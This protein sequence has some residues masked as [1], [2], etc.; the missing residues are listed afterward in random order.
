MG[1]NSDTIAAIST[2]NG[3]GGISVIRMSGD[4]ALKIADRIFITVS[5]KK[6]SEMKGYTAAYGSVYD[7]DNNKLDDA[8]ATVFR[9]P[10]SYTGEDV[11]EISCHGGMYIT[12]Q[13]L[14]AVIESG[15]SPAK[16]G[17]FTQRAFLNGKMDLSEAEAVMDIISAK[18][19]TE[20]RAA[21]ACMDGQISREIF[22]IN[23]ALVS[24]AAHLSA[25]ADYPEEDIPEVNSDNLRSD[26]SGIKNMIE[27]LLKNYDAGMIIK[28]GID[29][30]IAGKPNVGKS[31]LMNRLAGYEKSIVTDIPGTTRDIIEET[32]VL[33][34]VTLNLSDTAG[35]RDTDNIVEKIGVEKARQ[36][37][38]TS[39][40]VLAVFDSTQELDSED[41]SLISLIKDCPAVAVV[42]KNDGE[43]RLDINYLN[44][45][46]E[47]VVSISAKNGDGIEALVRTIEKITG[48]A[49][50]DPSVATLA[51]ERQRDCAVKALEAVNDAI[52]ALDMGFTL[53]A[54]TVS[55]EDAV[56]NILEITGERASEVVVHKVFS[57][58]CVGK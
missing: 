58:F 25:W 48:T 57:R 16:A 37:L 6:L 28:K 33:G 5:G 53:D 19:R 36:K 15:A 23:D 24:C 13:V 49:S 35:L 7:K 34:D 55:I 26:L 44:S 18:G 45:H 27:A 41:I 54:V 52:A 38:K 39:G 32:V 56:Q 46:I 14:R 20:A 21:L 40:L 11:T 12:K 3:A 47:N 29:T 22:R 31:T 50:F 1:F 10:H 51:N 8:V 42:N 4:D 17:E 9:K 2:P 30:I 43:S